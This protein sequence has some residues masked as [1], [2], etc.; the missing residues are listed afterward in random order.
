[1][2]IEKKLSE[3]E[4]ALKIHFDKAAEE[5]KT[6]GSTLD[7]TKSTLI[8]LQKQFDALVLELKKPG[9]GGAETKSLDQMLREDE[10][11]Q[12][13]IRDR[14]GRV[15][16]E[17]PGGLAQMLHKTTIT[18]SAIST[19][20][21]DAAT[22]GVIGYDRTPGVVPAARRRLFIQDLLTS[23]PTTL[24]TVEFVKVETDVS[25]ASPQVEGSAKH[26]NAL[27]FTTDTAPIRTIATWIP[28][29]KQILEDFPGLEAFI[30]SSL[31]WAVRKEIEDQIL[32]GDGTG[33]NIE[34]LITQATAFNTALLVAGDGW[35]YAD[36]IGRAIQQIQVSNESDP[37][38]V[39]IN[40]AIW[41]GI[42]LQ[43]A[44]DGQYIYG[45][46][47]N[48]AGNFQLFGLTV[49]PSNALTSTQFLVGSSD[50]SDAVI[51]TRTGL[52]VEISTEHSDYF[53]KNMVAIR[54]EQRIGL[55]VFRPQSYIT[56]TF[57]QSPA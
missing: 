43:K 30:R 7:E 29:T 53:V 38:F 21:N 26:E 55:Q 16:F 46:P 6:L 56:G 1:M 37:D 11:V 27:S 42:R 36:M 23:V 34:G 32:A 33:Q 9:N 15:Q 44:S 39:A 17:I 18:S 52:E 45:N 20:G 12:K 13:L 4:G 8:D 40:P 10:G 57:T 51:R 50:P 28:A 24:P 49:I 54:A 31:S 19:S 25:D 35:E 2:E 5:K 48:G 3:L 47:T 14:K 41:W 22:S